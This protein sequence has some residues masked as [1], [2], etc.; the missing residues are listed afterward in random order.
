MKRKKMKKQELQEKEGLWINNEVNFQMEKSLREKPDNE[1]EYSEGS[2]D[3]SSPFIKTCTMSRD[4]MAP[5][6]Q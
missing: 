4:S 1:R 5:R 6:I 2:A 3:I